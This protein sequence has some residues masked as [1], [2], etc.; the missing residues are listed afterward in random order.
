[1]ES[2]RNNYLFDKS[3]SNVNVASVLFRNI[4]L[5]MFDIK[6]IEIEY[7]SLWY[8]EIL[9]NIFINHAILLAVMMWHISKTPY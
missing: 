8:L 5:V 4:C 6:I 2:K 7:F 1:M 9:N 3:K